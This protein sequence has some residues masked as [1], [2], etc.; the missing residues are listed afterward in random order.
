MTGREDPA[1][2]FDQIVDPDVDLHD[3]AQRQEGKVRQWDIVA[4]V[5]L[6]GALGSVAR[7]EIGLALP[8]TDDQFPWSTVLVNVTG[9]L[10]LGALMVIVLELTAAHRL[11]RPFLGVGLLGGYTTFSTFTV[12]TQRLLADHRPLLALGYVATTVAL[13]AVAVW[14]AAIVTQRLGQALLARRR[15][16]STGR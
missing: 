12:D 8:H 10:C 5:A 6:G 11:V 13:G 14:L 2:E 9:S 3:P 1:A 16:R 15:R 7:Y 4:A